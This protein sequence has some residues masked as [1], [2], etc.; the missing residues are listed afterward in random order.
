VNIRD[1]TD[2]QASW[3]DVILGQ[4]WKKVLDSIMGPSSGAKKPA[5]RIK[6]REAGSDFEGDTKFQPRQLV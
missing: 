1:P 6:Y 4:A 5:N 3:Q 2:R